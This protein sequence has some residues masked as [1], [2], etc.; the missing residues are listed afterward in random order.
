MPRITHNP[1]QD[2][3]P[4][5]DDEDF[6]AVRDLIIAGHQGPEALTQEDAIGKL[7]TAW[8]AAQDKK[9]TAWNEQLLQD[10]TA[11]EE[12]EKIEQEAELQRRQEREKEEEDT[13]REVERKKPKINGFDL[14]M[15]IPGHIA[16]RPSSYALK[17][18]KN[19][20]Y[21]ELDYFT[22]KGCKEAQLERET[23]SNHDTLG[24]T[25]LENIVAFQPISSL[26]PSKNIRRD[27]E[28]MWDEMVFAK[29]KMLEHMADTETWPASHIKST[30]MLFLELE[31]HPTRPQYL[32]NVIMV[33]Y[34]ARARRQW[35][36]MLEQNKGF[37]LG[38]IGVDL[39]R[40]ITDEVRD[41]AR[42]DE[43]ATVRI[44]L[45]CPR[46]AA[47]IVFFFFFPLLPVLS[48]MSRTFH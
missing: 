23:T 9:L 17:K 24:L 38:K 15:V 29:N 40:N 43:L 47:L 22:I 33:T 2:E 6:A 30:M 20:Q 28:L 37:N 34:A 36:D 35:F 44:I 3:C 11:R 27:E 32:G 12:E 25:R 14:D 46:K 5:Y 21:V 8:Q 26:K 48:I 45:Q 16:P 10:Q 1:T 19:L 42:Q 41:K 39:M 31:N 4:T 18:I 13:K 7:R